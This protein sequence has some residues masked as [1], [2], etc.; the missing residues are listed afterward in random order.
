MTTTRYVISQPLLAG[1]AGLLPGEKSPLSPLHLENP[2][3]LT[4]EQILQLENAEILTRG[5]TLSDPVQQ[6][7]TSLSKIVAYARVRVSAPAGT[8]D[9]TVHFTAGGDQTVVLAS[10]GEDLVLFAPADV[11]ETTAEISELIG[12]GRR[13]PAMWAVELPPAEML[14]LAALLDLRRRAVLRSLAEQLPPV[15]LPSDPAA[16]G[17]AIASMSTD[18]LW[19]TA[20]VQTAA[21]LPAAAAAQVQ[22]A[23]S[24]LVEKKLA[25]Q[26]G[27]NFLPMPEAMQVAD[28]FLL[29]NTFLTLN[30]GSSNSQGR[31]VL[32]HQA[33]LG[34]GTG[35]LLNLTAAPDLLRLELTT[36]A[37]AL[38]Q[39]HTFLT[40]FD[41]L[42][43]PALELVPLALAIQNGMHTGKQFILGEETV[44]GRS[45]QADIHLLDSRA[46]RRN[47]VVR[48]L[49]EGFWLNDAGSTNGTFLN[50]LA[51]TSPTQLA[52]GDIILIGETQLKVVRA[53]ET[54]PPVQE[55]TP[56]LFVGDVMRLMAETPP[57]VSRIEPPSP[58]ESAFPALVPFTPVI[59]APPPAPTPA[60][61]PVP[62]NPPAASGQPEAQPLWFMPPPPPV[63]PA[64]VIPPPPILAPA[65][66]EA[67]PS[68]AGVRPLAASNPLQC[69]R[70]RESLS[71][72]DLVCTHC[73]QPVGQPVVGTTPVLP[74]TMVVCNK[75][76][77]PIDY[78]AR[79]CGTCGNQLP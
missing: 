26:H 64:P 2:L 78:G 17:A 13:A 37:A 33:W 41:A 46:S 32:A 74:Q 68:T 22:A 31:T 59:S 16:I 7:L 5:N 51:V 56:T 76:F 11:A 55:N 45:E 69:A 63:K 12:A 67:P 25:W 79:F 8:V 27:E 75:C 57:P 23:L 71:S 62:T 24:A 49:N 72:D 44:L 52:E 30:S 47:S 70:C 6:I 48:K 29:L 36:P 50:N 3:P 21:G 35:E 19:F 42:P 60:A 61:Q 73:G 66:F 38:D 40:R 18:P 39:I 14:A 43:A 4:P 15:L 58:A 53:E 10:S 65:P 20:A 34:A 9:Q 54:P 1:L 28:R 77:S